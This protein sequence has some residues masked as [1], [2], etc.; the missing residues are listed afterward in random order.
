MHGRVRGTQDYTLLVLRWLVLLGLAAPIVLPVGPAWPLAAPV[1]GPLALAVL[2]GAALYVLFL[3]IA[4]VGGWAGSPPFAHVQTCGD[5]AVLLALLAAAPASAE[6][7]VFAGLLAAAVVTGLRR[8]GA[9]ATGG[10][11]A[12]VLALGLLAQHAA[13]VEPTALALALA[14]AA[15]LLLTRL[16]AGPLPGEDLLDR[17]P[18]LRT[19]QAEALLG[20]AQRVQDRWEPHGLLAEVHRLLLRHTGAARAAIVLCAADGTAPRA[21]SFDAAGEAEVKAVAADSSADAPHVRALAGEVVCHEG[22]AAPLP[23]VEVVGRHGAS[24]AVG[25]PLRSQGE[26][27]GALVAYDKRGSAAFAEADVT[28]VRAL[29]GLA[30]A[31]L[32]SAQATAR[33]AEHADLVPRGLLALLTLRRPEQREHAEQVARIAAA[34]GEELGLDDAAC[35][36]LHLAALL[37]DLGELGVPGDPFGQRQVFSAES[38][39]RIKEHPTLGARVLAEIGYPANVLAMVQQHHERWD[40]LGYPQRLEGGAIVLGARILAVADALD[41]LTAERP[42]RAPRP[43]REAL[44]EIVAH[45]GT[46][47]DPAVVQALLA[48]VAR[49]GEQWVAAVPRREPAAVEPWR[50][51]VDRR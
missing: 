27:L 48:L 2:A 40:G 44:Q 39:E 1:E 16:L 29:A 13:L 5:L 31:A 17:R 3:T 32:H 46:Q 38:Y 24:S 45:S 15:A 10:Y 6:P 43:V 47:F 23:T 21:Y 51:R 49:H 9:P 41:A 14:P 20:L 12:A 25:A 22:R 8:F 19:D 37:H 35:R 28:F 34:L 7:L 42:Y 18:P 26:V 11:A 4:L 50:R 30:G 36:E 33:A